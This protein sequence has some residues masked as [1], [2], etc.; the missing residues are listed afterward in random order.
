M[1]CGPYTV[2]RENLRCRQETTNNG[3]VSSQLTTKSE[4]QIYEPDLDGR[5][6]KN[7]IR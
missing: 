7:L 6:F 4:D 1:F 3:I 5:A 2:A